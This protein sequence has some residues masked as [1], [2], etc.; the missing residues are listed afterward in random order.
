MVQG[1]VRTREYER[2][3]IRQR[4][5]EVRADSV[6]KLDRAE[7]RAESEATLNRTKNEP[8][9]PGSASAS[10][11]RILCIVQSPVSGHGF[12][13][14]TV[15]DVREPLEKRLFSGWQRQRCLLSL[16]VNNS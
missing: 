9:P 16:R 10:R 12:P 13:A 8:P 2:D 7:H 14:S 6:G 5:T 3:G 4:I 1:A 11:A 15:R